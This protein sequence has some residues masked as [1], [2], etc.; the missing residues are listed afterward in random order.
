MAD[1]TM[2][3]NRNWLLRMADEEANCEVSA[4]GLAHETGLL[5]RGGINESARLSLAK[6]L[7]LSRRQM[8]VSLE[9]LAE[10]AGVDLAELTS[11]EHGKSPVRNPQIL[12]RIAAALN[13]KAE[14]LLE[15]AGLLPTADGRLARIAVQFSARLESVKPLDPQE[16]LALRWFKEQ[17]F[18][19]R[20]GQVT[21]G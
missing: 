15:L 12:L 13:I 4:G 9:A 16:E 17:A 8:R 21:A 5:N 2:N 7:E 20:S 6:F 19:P 3:H 1:I 18:A 14:P 11:L 10:K